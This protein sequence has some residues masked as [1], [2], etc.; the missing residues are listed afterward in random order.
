MDVNLFEY[1]MKK[2]GFKS[3]KQRADALGISLPAYYRRTSLKSE[4]S[5]KEISK[6]SSLL[7]RDVACAIFFAE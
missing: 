5:L 7:G 3:A 1:E 2:A 4:C 6:V